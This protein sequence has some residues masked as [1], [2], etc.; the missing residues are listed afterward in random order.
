LGGLA[1]V[2][3]G[4]LAATRDGETSG[5]RVGDVVVT[6]PG[7]EIGSGA[8]L[9]LLVGDSQAV[10]LG[11]G[12]PA[13]PDA[14]VRV[15][16][17]AAVG[18]GIG[19]G[20]A[21]AEGAPVERDLSGES[22][23]TAVDRFVAARERFRP[24]LVLLHAGAWDILDRLVDGEVVSFGSARW[25][26]LTRLSISD[27]LE[28]LGAD[29]TRVV[30]LTAPCYPQGGQAGAAAFGEVALAYGRARTDEARVRRWNELLREQAGEL[31]VEVLPYD[32]LFCG[33]AGAGAPRRP[34]GV[35]LD[36]EGARAAWSWILARLDL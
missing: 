3:T 24:D 27:S 6:D 5:A 12:A 18:C 25:D 10:N 21:T 14:P 30:A 36:E 11:Q 13:G 33:P 17:A 7:D 19:A 22:C 29:G 9:L 23:F 26:S 20:L 15:A 35:H 32:E 16:G 8:P 4:I 2:A 31:G 1:L 28:R 34:D